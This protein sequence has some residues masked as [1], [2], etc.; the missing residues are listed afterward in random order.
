MKPI[1]LVV[2]NDAGTRRLLEVVLARAGFECDT[3]GSGDDALV[4]LRHV[5]YD[6]YF[7]DLMLPGVSGMDLIREL[8]ELIPDALRRT[9]VLTAAPLPYIERVRRM[10][11]ALSIVRKPFDLDEIIDF[12]RAAVAGRDA[13]ARDADEE[14]CRRSV[15]A[16]AK[17]GVL[18]RRN[19]EEVEPVLS[20]GYPPG[21]VE[22][23]FP[24]TVDHPIPLCDVMRNGRP[25]WLD[26]PS[27]AAAEYPSMAPLFE[28]HATRAM[29]IVPVFRD[30]IVV[31]AAGWTFREAHR[32][33][34]GEQRTFMAIAESYGTRI[35]ISGR[36]SG[37]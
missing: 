11:P 36:E 29:A 10:S 32:F 37:V 26:S 8:G 34:D 21:Y 28:K 9:A 2:E 23:F 6:A 22:T 18:V 20:Y 17:T 12:A 25:R 4:L 14:F 1:A 33:A 5:E 30:A 3:T 16:G 35:A 24:M 7:F 13:R 19:G 15:V 27:V 31:G